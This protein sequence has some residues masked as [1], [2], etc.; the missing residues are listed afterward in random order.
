MN[1]AFSD[2]LPYWKVVQLLNLIL[3]WEGKATTRR[4]VFSEI[5]GANWDDF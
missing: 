3:S 4:M 2:L 1:V 5:L